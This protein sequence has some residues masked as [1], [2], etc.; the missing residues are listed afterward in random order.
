MHAKPLTNRHDDVLQRLPA[1]SL[2]CCAVLMRSG[3]PAHTAE[4]PAL[5]MLLSRALFSTPQ[6]TSIAQLACCPS[7]PIQR[8][9]HG[10]R[11]GVG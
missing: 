1:N 11:H 10:P 6:I 2:A 8:L 3:W 5:H 7:L 4:I 9:P